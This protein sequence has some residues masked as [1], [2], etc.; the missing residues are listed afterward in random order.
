MESLDEQL[1]TLSLSNELNPFTKKEFSSKYYD[2]LEKR[3]S[4][5]IWHQKESFLQAFKDHQVLIVAGET[6]SGKTTQVSNSKCNVI[7]YAYF[8]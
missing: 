2:L 5:P 6:G 1:T 3:K 4:L 8:S 7:F